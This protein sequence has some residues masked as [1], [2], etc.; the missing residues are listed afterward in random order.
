MFRRTFKAKSIC[1]IDDTFDVLPG[2]ATAPA[3]HGAATY[4]LVTSSTAQQMDDYL[5]EAL[6]PIIQRGKH[7]D[8]EDEE[9]KVTALGYWR[10]KRVLS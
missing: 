5:S 1:K 10:N 9:K 7:P 8:K 6:I 2:A 4:W 3:V